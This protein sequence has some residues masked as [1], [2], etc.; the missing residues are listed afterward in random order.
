MICSGEQEYP[1]MLL[2][3]RV[4]S[5]S[6]HCPLLYNPLAAHII[7]LLRLWLCWV[8]AFG[9]ERARVRCERFVA[10]YDDSCRTRRTLLP[11]WTACIIRGVLRISD[12]CLCWAYSYYWSSLILLMIY[13]LRT[14]SYRVTDLCTIINYTALP[15]IWSA[16]P[17]SAFFLP[18]LVLKRWEGVA[19]GQ[20]PGAAHMVFF[21][22][23]PCFSG[24]LI[25]AASYF[26]QSLCVHCLNR[27]SPV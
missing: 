6:D 26:V 18:R 5:P 24:V 16:K 10:W 9:S 15:T 22:A 25:I 23:E 13:F 20:L 2:L 3:I 11:V 12:D 27:E 7:A 19:L 4:P 21:L 8:G 17:S 14:R 1:L